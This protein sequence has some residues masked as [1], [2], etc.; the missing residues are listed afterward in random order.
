MHIYP[1]KGLH[2]ND[3]QQ[4]CK[5]ANPIKHCK[6][7]HSF[8]CIFGGF[9]CSSA[10]PGH[11]LLGKH[12]SPICCCTT[13]LNK[14]IQAVP[15]HRDTFLSCKLN[16][17][18]SAA[19]LEC[20]L[21]KLFEFLCCCI[22]LDSNFNFS[23]WQNEAPA[24]TVPC[25]NDPVPTYI[26]IYQ[27]LFNLNPLAIKEKLCKGRKLIDYATHLQ[28]VPVLH[29]TCVKVTKTTEGLNLNHKV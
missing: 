12:Y 5:C 2:W 1:C 18:A 15:H 21:I 20:F 27:I 10:M 14:W 8:S 24:R 17:I 25:T 23:F 13:E 6:C 9:A 7:I 29:T 4:M 16:F 11:C 19:C 3:M 26:D 22:I 28:V